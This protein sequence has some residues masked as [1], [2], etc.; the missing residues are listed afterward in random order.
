MT[1]FTPHDGAPCLSAGEAQV[2][3]RSVS[4]IDWRAFSVDVQARWQRPVD[5]K[6]AL[7]FSQSTLMAAW[8][9]KP[10]GTLPMLQACAAMGAHPLRYL[11]SECPRNG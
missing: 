5:M 10:I 9:G 8:H 4:A 3:D 7:G 1:T 2:G 6:E 11:I